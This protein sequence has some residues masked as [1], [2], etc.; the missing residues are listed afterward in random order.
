MVYGGAGSETY[1]HVHRLRSAVADAA[2]LSERSGHVS[3][4][5]AASQLAGFATWHS[6]AAMVE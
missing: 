6:A 3:W 1:V 5:V 4:L 2:S